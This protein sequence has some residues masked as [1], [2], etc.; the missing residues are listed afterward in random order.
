MKREKTLISGIPA[1]VWGEPSDRA[2]IHKQKKMSRKEYAESF[3][4][5]F[6]KM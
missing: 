6:N 1:I 3:A 4:D 5:Y 2:Y